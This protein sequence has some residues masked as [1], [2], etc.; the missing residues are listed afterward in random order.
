MIYNT[1]MAPIK[2]LPNDVINQI[3]AGEVVQKPYNAI[4]EMIE[5]SLDAQSHS[6]SLTIKNGGLQLIQIVDDGTGI[7]REDLPLVCER[8]A[9]SKLK[10]IDDLDGIGTFGFRGEALAS[11]SYVSTVTI[12]SRTPSSPIAFR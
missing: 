2:K 1:N 4:K 3:A 7:D 12:T 5:N 10:S 6:I 8:F 11:I 9:T